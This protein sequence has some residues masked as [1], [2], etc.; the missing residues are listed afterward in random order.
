MATKHEIIGEEWHERAAELAEWAMQNMVNRKDVWGQYSVLTPAEQR[1]EKRSYK[2]MTLPRKDMRGE[3]MVTI[4]KLTRHFASRHYHKPQIIGLHAKSKESTSR[5]LGIDIDCHETNSV[6]AEDHARRNLVGA[7][8]WWK[9]FQTLGYDP[10][11]ID[12]SGQGGYHLWVLFREPAPTADI[13][14]LA[15]NMV[16]TWERN[17]L[18]EEPETFP[19]RPKEGSLGS[20]F[21]LPG[22]HHTH[23][24]YGRIWSGDDWLDNPWLEGHAAIDAILNVM[25][26]P[27]PPKSEGLEIRP[28]KTRHST[29]SAKKA[30]TRKMRFKSTGKATVC[31]DLD[32]VL[33]DRIYTKGIS[34]I[35]E[36][37]DGAVDFTRS[38]ADFADIV[39]LTSRFSGLEGSEEIKRMED[40]IAVWLDLHR[41]SYTTI[42]TESAK[43]PAQAYIDDHGVYC[44][45]SKE[46]IGAFESARI[47]TMALCK[48]DNTE[49]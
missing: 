31:L 27:P 1:R 20:W 28:R 32:G 17:N 39:I 45:P 26:G 21:R 38:I 3:D 22:L 30:T 9:Q 14:A 19:K 35:G 34:E 4:D 40:K 44:C 5:W 24:H 11:L 41:F 16:S 23:E 42:W 48:I 29:A 25:P 37:I 47:A 18:D 15:K 8:N 49:G 36:P 43:P 10:L 2:A 13:Y 46:G 33:A 12:S 7:L 6:M